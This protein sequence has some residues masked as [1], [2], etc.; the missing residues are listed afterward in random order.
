[1]EE[2]MLSNNMVAQVNSIVFSIVE[3]VHRAIK[4]MIEEELRNQKYKTQLGWHTQHQKIHPTKSDFIGHIPT[5]R[6]QH[7]SHFARQPKFYVW[8]V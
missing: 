5:I 4:S 2:C 8:K 1:M 3:S 6:T 7:R